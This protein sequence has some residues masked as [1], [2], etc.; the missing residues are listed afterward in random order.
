MFQQHCRSLYVDIDYSAS[1]LGKLL[2]Q[3]F[4][5]LSG[6]HGYIKSGVVV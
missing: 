5:P 2:F 1:G 6:M 4:A 3:I